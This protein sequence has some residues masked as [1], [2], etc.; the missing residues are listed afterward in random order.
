MKKVVILAFC[1]LIC[2]SSIIADETPV[3][4][5]NHISLS[6]GV[7]MSEIAYSRDMGRF[8]VGGGI[9]S[10]FPNLFIIATISDPENVL[11]NLKE[12]FTTAA[13]AEVYGSFDIIPS[14]RHDLDI[15]I[16]IEALYLNIFE[17]D[18]MGIFLNGKLRYSYNFKNNGRLFLGISVPTLTY[19][20]NLDGG[21]GG[22]GIFQGEGAL[23]MAGL[24]GTQI[25]YAFAF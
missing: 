24:V 18:I 22:F 20:F 21:E 13:K 3:E 5:K 11:F 14:E 2:I 25:G 17:N 19:T 6:T 4:K 10:G 1:V 9:N 7:F 15:G 12:S 8:E 23:A 16:G